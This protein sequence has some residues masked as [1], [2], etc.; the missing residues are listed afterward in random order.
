MADRIIKPQAGFQQAF[1]SSPADIVVGGGAAGGG[2]SYA[3][4]LDP[5]RYF[6]IKGFGAVIFRRTTP[7]IRNEGSLW[8]TSIQLYQPLG[9]NAREFLLQ[10]DFDEGSRVRFSHMEYEKNKYDHQGG[11][12]P[13]IGFDE[14]T[15]F[16]KTQ[17]LYLVGRNRSPV[18]G[19]KPCIR[20]T[21][22]PDP[23]S[24]VADFISWWINQDTG[25]PIPER[26]GK[27]RYFTT[28]KG[29]F[30]WG[31]SVQEVIDRCPHVF[32]DDTL[33]GQ[34]PEDLVKSVTFIPGDVYENK[35]LLANDPGYLANLLALPEEEQLRL[36]KGNWKIR[37]D[38][39][40]LFNFLRVNDLFTNAVENSTDRYITVDAARFGSN[41]AV[42]KTWVG[43]RV[44]KTIIFTKS[45]TSTL[46]KA[47]EAE[48]TRNKV[49]KSQ[50][51]VDQDGVGGGVVDEGGYIGFS[52]GAR[53]IEDPNTQIKEN[54]KNLKTQCY[55]RF[56]ERV[57]RAEVAVN[58]TFIVD[59][60]EASEVTISGQNYDI[61]KLIKE[62][63]RCVRKKTS[64][65]VERKQIN[66]KEEQKNILGGRSPDFSDTLM[67]REY[68]ELIRGKLVT[69]E[70]YAF[71]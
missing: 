42:I 16:T 1:L 55:Y 2:K 24:W 67:M 33:H 14:L 25:Y 23:D 29:V 7:Q 9:G 17:F 68:F 69:D 53:V 40:A 38:G 61:V 58:E 41:L 11:Q 13:Y 20:A 60:N 31:D 47:I 4:L 39:M 10:W 65:D 70:D 56:A 59:G 3:L 48:R 51:L 32:N 35:E 63:L 27:I 30:V 45:S 46:V 71:I 54:Y 5:A 43:W 6:H 49:P 44:I 12:Y 62:D 19:V 28:D 36:L 8:D 22:N 15:Q 52:G 66:S 26:A 21:C 34:A 57:N 50:I 37:Q 64:T 18:A